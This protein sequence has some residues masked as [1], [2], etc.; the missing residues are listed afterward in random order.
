V[1]YIISNTLYRFTDELSIMDR[2]PILFADGLLIGMIYEI[3]K[4]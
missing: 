3:E 1:I 2:A 4:L